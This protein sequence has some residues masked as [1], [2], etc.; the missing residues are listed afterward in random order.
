MV[1]SSET[2]MYLESSGAGRDS[3]VL[4]Y[5]VVCVDCVAIQMQLLSKSECQRYLCDKHVFLFYDCF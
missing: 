5:V 2:W 1:E 3:G 4:I